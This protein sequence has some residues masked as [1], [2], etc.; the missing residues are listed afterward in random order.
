MSTHF[1]IEKTTQIAKEKYYWPKMKDDIEIYIKSCNQCQRRNKPQNKNKL[2]PVEV[3]EPFYQIGIDFVGPLPIT[4][5]NNK[6]IIVAMDYFT[7]WP[8]A[9]PVPEATALET[10]RFIYS[11]IICRHGCPQIISSD[12]GSHFNNKMI[13]ELMKQFRIKQ[14]FST[15]YHPKTNRLVERF[16][17]I[18]CKSLAKL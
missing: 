5:N 17:K 3:Q 4:P 16:N 7:K 8:E 9:K 11:D 12:R 18:L 10:A 6:Y 13:E 14:I 1:E 15:L 2:Q